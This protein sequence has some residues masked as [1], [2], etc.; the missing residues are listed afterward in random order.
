MDD[1][2]QQ[3]LFA[4]TPGSIEP[5]ETGLYLGTSG[6]SY[7]D[8]EGT[9]YPEALPSASRLAEYVK[10]Y[11]TVEIDSTFYGTPRRS[12]VQKWR[13]VS[14]DGFL[15]AAKFPEEFS[16]PPTNPFS[17]SPVSPA[18]PGGPKR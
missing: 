1:S 13:E 8:W 14:P 12:T 6:W 15:F 17:F 5:P 11:A 9:L 3:R 4:E 2:A 10:R 16:I 18:P 7:A